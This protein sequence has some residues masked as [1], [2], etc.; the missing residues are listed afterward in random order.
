MKNKSSI[1]VAAFLVAL[2][3]VG[4]LIYMSGASQNGAGGVGGGLFDNSST[5]ASTQNQN[6][7]GNGG[8]VGAVFSSSD[9]AFSVTPL[10]DEI[11]SQMDDQGDGSAT[12][13][14]NKNG[15]GVVAQIIVS[16]YDDTPESLTQAKI[17]GDTGITASDW[18]KVTVGGAPA[19]SFTDTSDSPE[20]AQVWL[21]HGGF[22]YQISAEKSVVG[23]T[24]ANLL[25]TLKL[26]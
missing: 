19:L 6:S 10:A 1:Y 13:V 3:L 4:G 8:V 18:Q 21:V 15:S 9:Y 20:S 23:S 5:T 17:I 22:L 16:P 2:V 12:F 24:L 26:R 14:I 11:V 7:G 25:A